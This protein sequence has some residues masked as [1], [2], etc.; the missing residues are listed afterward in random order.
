M[1]KKIQILFLSCFVFSF[2][3]Y[4]KVSD[5]PIITKLMI[6]QL[7]IRDAEP[8]NQFILEAELWIGKDL[9]KFWIK[10][11]VEQVGGNA[12]EVELQLL[13][14]RA[15]APFW[16]FQV[17]L[18]RD[19]KPK[20]TRD[21]FAIGFKGLAPYYFE[22]DTALFFGEDN[23]TAL[24]LEAEYEMLF[25]QKLILSPEVEANFFSKTDT[26]TEV[27]SGLSDLSF[28]LRLRY[29]IKREFA[30]YIGVYWSKKY[31]GTA[32][33]ARAAGVKTSDTQFVIGIRAWF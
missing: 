16:D 30:P 14:S 15:I 11:E 32:D 28:G 1:N 20:P 5:D 9:N 12:E 23:Q 22:I 29:E 8:D 31:G 7:E 25:T 21:W 13:Y 19:F 6:D 26:E 18:R 10:T 33:F 17:G 2:N 3:L 24:R 27:G 4:A